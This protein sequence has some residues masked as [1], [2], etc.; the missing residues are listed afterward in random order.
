ML[1]R[2]CFS[3][4]RADGDV[5]QLVIA[6]HG[7]GAGWSRRRTRFRCRHSPAA[8]PLPTIDPALPARAGTAA[9]AYRGSAAGGS[10]AAAVRGPHAYH[11]LTASRSAAAPD[12]GSVPLVSGP[13]WFWERAPFRFCRTN[14]TGYPCTSFSCGHR[15]SARR[16]PG[17]GARRS[18]TV[19]TDDG[20]RPAWVGLRRATCAPSH[21]A[22][23]RSTPAGR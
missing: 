21:C 14:Q 4:H 17:G 16:P 6:G 13:G 20:R 3:I 11:R 22:A 7:K 1:L 15:G 12:S 9:H 19:T 23:G 10:T 8:F 2:R 5:M 18:V